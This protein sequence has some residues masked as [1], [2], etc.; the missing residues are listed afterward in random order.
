VKLARLLIVDDQKLIATSLQGI[1]KDL[2]KDILGE[3]AIASTGDE[4]LSRMNAF[5]ADLVLMDIFMPGISGLEALKMIK[6]KYPEAK[7]LMLTT[8][9]YDSYVQEAMGNGACG[10]LLKDTTPQEVL[11]AI[12]NALEGRIVLSQPALDALAGKARVFKA[13]KSV[14]PEWFP[15]LTEKEKSILLLISRGLSNDEIA[16][17]LN[18]GKNTVRNYVS[19]IYEK[20]GAEDRF[21]A[22]RVAI[23]AQIHTLVME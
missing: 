22:M 18:L 2:G 15:S 23:E 16:D 8:F 3:I 7:V 1:L 10:Y 4:A 17:R 6:E 12:R 5:H 19:S 14:V 20:I 11:E 21:H 13:Q 9:G